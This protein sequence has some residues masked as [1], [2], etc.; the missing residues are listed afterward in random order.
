[1]TELDPQRVRE[2]LIAARD[3]TRAA[4]A[5]SLAGGTATVQRL[6]QSTRVRALVAERLARIGLDAAA[7]ERELAAERAEGHRRLGELKADAVAQSAS[8]AASLSR[9]VNNEVTV[10]DGL[11]ATTGPG[12]TQYQTLDSPVEIWATDGMNLE[13][14]TIAPYNSLAKAR[15][16][17]RFYHEGTGAWLETV[18]QELLHFYYLWGN[19]RQDAYAVLTVSAILA[20]NGFCSAHSRGGLI[21]GGDA[22]L[23]LDPTLDLVRT[24]TQPIS[25]APPQV[26][27]S[28][29]ALDITADSTGVFTDDQTTYAVEFR[30]FQLSYEQAI[31]PPGQ[32]LIIDV[33][34]SLTSNFLDGEVSADFATGLFYVLSPFVQLAIMFPDPGAMA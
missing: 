19:P 15:Y 14:S 21:E 7:V 18:G 20:L 30:G 11:E 1:M 29:H 13:S 26:G 8:R 31:V 6:P 12:T 2:A 25:S 3:M 22:R 10:L 5:R 17:G 32:Y 24:W 16:D 28:W 27:Q 33:A 4:D 34:L 23:Q 9:V